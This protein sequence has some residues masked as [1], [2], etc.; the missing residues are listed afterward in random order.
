MVGYSPKQCYWWSDLSEIGGKYW[1]QLKRLVC[2]QELWSHMPD[3]LKLYWN[4]FKICFIIFILECQILSKTLINLLLID[5]FTYWTIGK[6]I[7]SQIKVKMCKYT[8]VLQS[9]SLYFC[10]PL[11]SYVVLKMKYCTTNWIVSLWMKKW[12]NV[13]N[14]KDNYN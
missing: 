14:V 5:G 1:W 7:F 2:C 10:I 9:W 8:S 11:K 3:F 6:I 13:N 12:N 4:I